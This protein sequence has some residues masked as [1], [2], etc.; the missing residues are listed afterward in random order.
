MRETFKQRLREARERV[1]CSQRGLGV[2]MGLP[3]KKASVYI[4]RWERQGKQPNWEAI[5]KMAGVLEVPAAFFLAD[6]DTLAE[7]ILLAGGMPSAE[8]EALV[9]TLRERGSHQ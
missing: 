3:P 9:A 5:E 6:D 7:I 8:K 1:E 2:R 4:N